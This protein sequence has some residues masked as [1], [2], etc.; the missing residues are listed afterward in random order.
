MDR[1]YLASRPFSW[2]PVDLGR[3]RWWT[4]IRVGPGVIRGH[5]PSLRAVGPP[6]WEFPGRK[7]PASSAPVSAWDERGPC[8]QAA[9]G[10]GLEATFGLQ[11]ALN[12]E[13]VGQNQSAG[14]GV[15]GQKPL[16]RE[17]VPS[18]ILLSVLPL[19][20][21]LPALCLVTQSS[22]RCR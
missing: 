10:A 9:E 12:L 1:K 18:W 17:S 19:S 8:S 11:F 3:G 5:P 14:R 4:E 2:V 15:G 16:P 6:L 21:V 7:A 13:T 20:P 22:S